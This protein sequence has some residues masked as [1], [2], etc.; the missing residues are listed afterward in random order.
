MA[1]RTAIAALLATVALLYGNGLASDF[2]WDDASVVLER[3]GFFADPANIR[4][5]LTSED[6]THVTGA[7]NPYYRPLNILSYMLD[8]HLWGHDPFWYHLENLLLHALAVVLLFLLVEGAFDDRL[9][10][11]VTALVF[12]VHPVNSESVSFISARNNILCATLFFGSLL[13]LC[14]SRGAGWQA[15]L[16]ALLLFLLALAS[17]EPAVVIPF[18]LAS[19]TCFTRKESLATDRRALLAYFAVL[20]AYFVIR[21]LV[22]GTFTSKSGPALSLE[23]LRLMA[24]VYCENFRLILF[25]FHLNAHYTREFLAF[26]WASAAVAVSGIGLLVFFSLWRRSPEPVRAGCQWTFWGLLPVSNLVAIP[27]APVAER[28]L[29]AVVPGSALVAAY[30]V[31]QL[32]RRNAVRPVALIALVAAVVV[33]LGAR[34]FTRNRVWADDLTLDTSMIRSDP[35]NAFAT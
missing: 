22:L 13:A 6:S 27:S 1:R 23:K 20:L 3:S 25:P 35:S 33:A 29:Y 31:R 11:F 10:A 18:F 19:L 16:A 17:K 21:F 12:A 8:Y 30:L 15:A 2:V 28:Y 7:K 26:G 32:Q 5:I 24:S 4:T 34:T 14:R 9:L